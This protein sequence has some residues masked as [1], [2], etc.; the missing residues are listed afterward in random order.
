MITNNAPM[1]STEIVMMVLELSEGGERERERESVIIRK[2]Q[3]VHATQRNNRCNIINNL[4]YSKDA[5]IRQATK[6]IETISTERLP[7]SRP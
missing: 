7:K 1:M 3:H 5:C 4:T 6:R 2:S